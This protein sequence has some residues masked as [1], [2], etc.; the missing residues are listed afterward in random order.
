MEQIKKET[1]RE[2][3]QTMSAADLEL[4]RTLTDV[5][6]DELRIHNTNPMSLDMGFGETHYDS[7][8]QL[9]RSQVHSFYT[10]PN[11]S[12]GHSQHQY[13]MGQLMG[14]D[15][16]LSDDDTA[17]GVFN[18]Y[19]DPNLTTLDKKSGCAVPATG[20]GPT[21]T[22]GPAAIVK[23][24]N[25]NLTPVQPTISLN[26]ITPNPFLQSSARFPNAQQI[27]QNNPNNHH[28]GM[29]NGR[30]NSVRGFN[31]QTRINNENGF[32]DEF[33]NEGYGDFN[34]MYEEDE[35]L[36]A[37][38]TLWDDQNMAGYYW[39]NDQDTLSRFDQEFNFDDDLSDEEEE[40]EE[41]EEREYEENADGGK[42]N[43]ELT[44]KILNDLQDDFSDSEEVSTKSNEESLYMDT[45]QRLNENQQRDLSQVTVP[46][47]ESIKSSV[48]EENEK[49]EEEEEEG[50]D[51]GDAMFSE[52]DEDPL[53]EPALVSPRRKPSMVISQQ[54]SNKQRQLLTINTRK[55]HEVS[56]NKLDPKSTNT[57]GS[58]TMTRNRGNHQ[59]GKSVDALLSVDRSYGSSNTHTHIHHSHNQNDEHICMVNNP[60][61]NEPCMKKFSRPYDLIRHQK[62]IHASKKKIF[63]CLICIQ[64]LGSEGYQRTFSRNDALSRHVKV[65]HNL[66]GT[67]AQRV[68]QYAKDN[69]EYQ[70]S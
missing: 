29:S 67:E 44:D 33:L 42:N 25:L 59:R 62:T 61:T 4:R 36:T 26:T 11:F 24:V 60:V 46:R 53:Y 18:K 51:E 40:E 48:L 41:E 20:P 7:F 5:V 30:L 37:Q 54:N 39:T 32:E 9:T 63:R 22:T 70:N 1:D 64:E 21:A 68:I 49:L 35:K 17:S 55:S 6:D 28:N 3:K 8:P 66:Q 34:N 10:G 19:A 15:L 27:P 16:H 65:K 56:D 2:R 47:I 58:R 23:Q 38:A 45:Q 57:T 50:D 31:F 52:D 13:N 12:S 69:V 14:H 43:T